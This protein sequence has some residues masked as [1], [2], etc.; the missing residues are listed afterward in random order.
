[1]MKPCCVYILYRIS[2]NCSFSTY[3]I[4][5]EPRKR[6]DSF[7]KSTAVEERP[8]PKHRHGGYRHRPKYFH[9]KETSRIIVCGHKWQA[10]D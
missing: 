5:P 7:G 10:R 1:M 9:N 8:I 2:S 3:C 4:S 6:S